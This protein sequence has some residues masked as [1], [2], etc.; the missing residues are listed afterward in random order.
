MIL[1]VVV[2]IR[3]SGAC[4]VR[5]AESDVVFVNGKVDVVN[6]NVFNEAARLL[7]N[8]GSLSSL[9]CRQY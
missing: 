2:V 9:R 6:G 4:C 1:V 5:G 3:G 8:V 7:N